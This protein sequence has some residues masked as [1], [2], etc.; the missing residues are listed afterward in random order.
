MNTGNTK[1]RTKRCGK[2]RYEIELHFDKCSTS[3]EFKQ[4]NE[5]SETT[6]SRTMNIN[7]NAPQTMYHQMRNY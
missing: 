4:V 1:D 3:E 5:R 6:I 7:L 2:P